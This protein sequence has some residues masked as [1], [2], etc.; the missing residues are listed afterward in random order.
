MPEDRSLIE[1]ALATQGFVR[2]MDIRYRHKSGEIRHAQ[3]SAEVIILENG[4]K[5][6]LSVM[7]DITEY[8]Q[9]DE[10]LRESEAR[11]RAMLNA[12]PDM[13]FRMDSNGTFLDYKADTKDLY[14]QSVSLIGQRN[15]DMVDALMAAD[16]M[17]SRGL[18][19]HG[20]P[21]P[22][23]QGPRLVEALDQRV[24]NK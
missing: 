23:G 8:K 20:P 7:R 15:R 24:A 9:A 10:K 18:K 17:H 5:C 21:G 3:A 1:Q 22:P 2:N 12:I 4:Q 19:A 16:R 14:E 11:A 6:Q 13:M